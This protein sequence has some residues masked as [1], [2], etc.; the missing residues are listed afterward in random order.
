MQGFYLYNCGRL[1]VEFI[2]RAFYFIKCFSAHM[3]VQHGGSDAVMP[4]QMLYNP[5]ICSGFHQMGGIA[6]PQHMNTA[7]RSGA[8]TT[9]NIP[10]GLPAVLWTMAPYGL[11]FPWPPVYVSA[12][13]YCLY[14]SASVRLFHLPAIPLNILP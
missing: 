8:C 12:F 2:Q 1:P 5:D 3:G 13:V 9:C 4:Q 11:S 14:Y 7:D 10:A 6:V